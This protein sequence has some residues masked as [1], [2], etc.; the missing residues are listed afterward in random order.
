MRS[1]RSHAARSRELNEG[2]VMHR[3]VI[4]ATVNDGE[5]ARW[6]EEQ[7]WFLLATEIS[8]RGASATATCSSK[9]ELVGTMYIERTSKVLGDVAVRRL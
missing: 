3:N 5:G 2:M 4:E 1:R 7:W 8:G 6:V 9:Q